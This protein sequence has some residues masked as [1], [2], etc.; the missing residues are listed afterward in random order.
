MDNTTSKLTI[1]SIPTSIQETKHIF[2]CQEPVA[3]GIVRSTRRGPAGDLTIRLR[4]DIVFNF[5]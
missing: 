5:A 1:Y 3:A 2:A 4:D